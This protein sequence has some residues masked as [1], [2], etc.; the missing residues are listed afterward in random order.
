[1]KPDK[2]HVLITGASRGLGREMA[3]ALAEDGFR[4]FAGVRSPADFERMAAA[5]PNLVPLR[6]DVTDA[7]QITE[8]VRTVSRH[9]DRLDGLVDNAGIFLVGPLSKVPPWPTWSTPS[10]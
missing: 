8:A 5:S 10:A 4:V 1:M 2:R 9:T 7:D 6:L 3:Q